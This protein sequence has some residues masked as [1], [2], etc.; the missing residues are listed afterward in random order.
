LMLASGW[1]YDIVAS[2]GTPARR[3]VPL[4]TAAAGGDERTVCHA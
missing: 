1:A 4:A 2:V 3:N